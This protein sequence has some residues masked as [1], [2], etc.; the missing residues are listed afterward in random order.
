MSRYFANPQFRSK[1]VAKTYYLRH[2]NG[3]RIRTDKLIN[4]IW[5][6]ADGR[7]LEEIKEAIEGRVS[8]SAWLLE[9]I[10][11]LMV[12]ADLL[13]IDESKAPQPDQPPVKTGPLVSI[14]IVNKDGE[15]HLRTLLPSISRQD[16]PNL[17]IVMVDNGSRDESSGTVR[18]FFPDAKVIELEKNIGFSAGNNV[19]IEAASGEYL[20]LLNNDTELAHD[21]VSRLVETAIRQDDVAA[22][23]PKMFLWRLPRFLNGIGNSV[24]PQGWGGDN[25]IGY[26]DV[27]QFDH[28]EQVSSACFGAAMLTRDALDKVGW[29]DPKY[30]FYYEDADWSYRARLLGLNIYFAPGAAVFH[31]FSA[32]MNT[33]AANFKW[34]L[35]IG[36]RLR[37]IT[38]NL[39]KGAWLNFMRNYFREDVRATLRSVKH[40]DFSMAITYIRAWTQFLLGLPG[41]LAARRRIQKTR[42]IRD[43]AIFDL[44]PDLP[45]LMDEGGNPIFD[46]ATV[47]RIYVHFL[48]EVGNG[49]A[50]ADDFIEDEDEGIELSLDA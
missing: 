35:V 12:A 2:Q 8:V 26:L 18:E 36:N 6:K 14:I 5:E 28:D 25:Y 15:E 16:Y 4:T 32:S 1:K 10:M 20:F 13:R 7:S 50:A 38:K 42:V 19:G 27:G 23:I 3:A 43:K 30:L 40:R 29:L 31:K 45:P 39:S 11:R 21:C 9:A 34:R 17:E 48:E 24:R 44:W 47:R 49:S 46:V 22:V 37:F 33:L 41:I